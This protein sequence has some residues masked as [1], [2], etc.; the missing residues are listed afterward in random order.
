MLYKVL[1]PDGRCFYGGQGQW[2]L[3]GHGHPGKWMPKV[4]E[5]LELCRFG[6]HLLNLEQLRYWLVIPAL[7]EAE[8][9]GMGLGGI[10]KTCWTQ[11]RLLRKVSTWN[12]KKSSFLYCCDCLDHAVGVSAAA[13]A[14]RAYIDGTSPI[15]GALDAADLLGNDPILG[16]LQYSFRSVLYQVDPNYDPYGSVRWHFI[17]F[18][19]ALLKIPT[20]KSARAAEIRWQNQ[21]L[22]D[23]LYHPEIQ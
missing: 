18:F 11:A 16:L 3:P 10:D 1:Q 23:M 12:S 9:R 22:H 19:K 8:G 14:A 20:T 4:T 7:F 15:H 17:S 13:T 5:P 6:Y 21:H 2:G